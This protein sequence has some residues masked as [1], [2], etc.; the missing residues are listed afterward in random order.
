MLMSGWAMS[1][2]AAQVRSLDGIMGRI[3]SDLTS[4]GVWSGEDAERFERDWHDQVRSRLLN[5]A[6]KMDHI[7]YETMD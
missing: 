4:A 1:G 7:Q 2:A 5:A 3:V 6:S